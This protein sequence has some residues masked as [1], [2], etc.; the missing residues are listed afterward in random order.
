MRRHSY[1]AHDTDPNPF[2][3][4]LQAMRLLDTQT[5]QFV[6]EDPACVEYAILSHTWRSNGEQTY[7]ELREI[8][9]RYPPLP[10]SQRPPESLHSSSR[11][12]VPSSES[13]FHQTPLGR[14]TASTVDPV[15]LQSS[16]SNWHPLD[17]ALR[18]KTSS[19]EPVPQ[20]RSY[21]Q[22]STAP[23]DPASTPGPVQRYVLCY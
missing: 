15:P 19:Y 2:P 11:Y 16:P 3:R 9:K 20:P 22:L 21:Y 5:G 1:Q 23:V 7:Q 14:I 13:V 8:Q 18:S 12:H 6:E 4:K 10:R 17:G